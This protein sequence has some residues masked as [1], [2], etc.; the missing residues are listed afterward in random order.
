MPAGRPRKPLD[1]QKGN[2]TVKQQIEKKQAEEIYKVGK[3]SLSKPPDCLINATA[4][5]EYKRVVELLKSIDI[6]CDLDINN[7]VGYAN[8]YAQYCKATKELEHAKLVDF[9]I[10]KSNPLCQVQ[11]LYAEEM[12]KFGSLIGLDINSRLK[13]SSAKVDEIN[14]NIDDE[15]GAI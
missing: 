7:I 3:D 6:I 15:F 12:R 5:K 8:A 2:L 4:R 10:V 13:M 1:A 11:K 14:K 9:N